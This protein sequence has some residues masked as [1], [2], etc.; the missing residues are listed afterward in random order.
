[1]DNSWVW[2]PTSKPDL[3]LVYL[4]TKINWY[5]YLAHRKINDNN[6]RFKKVLVRNKSPLSRC[7]SSSDYNLDSIDNDRELID[8]VEWVI[9]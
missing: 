7:V 5:Y 3:I 6:I 1:M 9:I 8:M 4:E 2:L